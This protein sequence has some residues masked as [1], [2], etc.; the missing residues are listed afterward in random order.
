MLKVKDTNF[1]SE[2]SSFFKNNDASKAMNS[3]MNIISGLNISER[4]LFGR[5]TRFNSRYSLLQILTCLILFPCFMIRNPYNFSNTRLGSMMGCG[6]DVFYR[7][8]QDDRINWRKLLYHLNMQLWNKIR[9]RSDHKNCTTCLIVDDTD[10][11]KTGKRFELMGRV[12]SHVE[13]KSILGFKALT[14]AIT[15]GISQMVLDFALVGEPGK[16]NNFSMT[17]GELAA[18]YSKS[19]SKEAAVRERIEEYSLSKITLTIDMIKRA[20]KKGIRFRYILADSWFACSEIIKFVH[21]RRIGCDYLGMI[22]VGEKGRTKYRFERKD[23]TAPALVKLLKTRK[24][25]KYSRKLKCYYA[26]ADVVFADTRVRLFFLRRGKQGKWNGLITTDLSLDFFEAYRIY[27]QR[28]ALEVVFK[29]SK[30]MLGL[31]KC[32]ARDFASQIA[33]TSLV[34]IQYNLLSVV[35]RFNAYETIGAL[36]RETCSGAMELTIVERIWGAVL[37]M[38][39]AMAN[40][41][42]LEEEDV[43]D[44]IINQS[45]E[46]AHIY[47][48]YRLKLA[49]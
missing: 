36:F 42:N 35:K 4:T 6:K 40:V 16:K 3:M 22:K 1:L 23:L 31:G 18:R 41:F 19:R 9:V 2:I 26:A 43:Y 46:L 29:D 27:S 37:E 21:S 47:D 5:T 48:I 15:D 33:C 11:G 10:F 20:I 38:V 13:H 34:A 39:I 12:F 24:Q 49:V 8:A 25:I 44:A 17:A 32:Q 30:S 45:D 7:F 28:W 14:L